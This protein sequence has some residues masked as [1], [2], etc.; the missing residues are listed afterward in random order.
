MTDEKNWTLERL[1]AG[2]VPYVLKKA[3]EV[4]VLDDY[5]K[6]LHVQIRG[7]W[8]MPERDIVFRMHKQIMSNGRMVAIVRAVDHPSVPPA[9]GV[10]RITCELSGA[11]FDPFED[12]SDRCWV[13]QIYEGDPHGWIPESFISLG[14]TQLAPQ[15]LW[16]INRILSTPK[17]R[18]MAVAAHK[19]ATGAN[20]SPS[21]DPGQGSGTVSHAPHRPPQHQQQPLPPPVSHR[22]AVDAVAR[23]PAPPSSVLSRVRSALVWVS[24]FMVT[25]VYFLVLYNFFRREKKRL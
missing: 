10:T 24:P 22:P 23:R 16:L 18:A 3:S 17:A 6:I 21:S 14:C 11:V 8:P 7:L 25:V 20:P 1:S 9:R 13:T 12:G 19:A 15:A 5:T 4:E 2:R